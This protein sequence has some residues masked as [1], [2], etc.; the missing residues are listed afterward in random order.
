METKLPMSETLK[1]KARRFPDRPGVYI[2]HD[3]SGRVIYVGKARSLK[4]R[5]LS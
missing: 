2:M 3:E 4:K 1:D 5:V